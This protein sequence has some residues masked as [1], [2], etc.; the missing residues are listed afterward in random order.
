MAGESLT[1][2]KRLDYID[3]VGIVGAVITPFLLELGVSTE[4]PSEK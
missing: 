3:V 4:E 2:L 1:N